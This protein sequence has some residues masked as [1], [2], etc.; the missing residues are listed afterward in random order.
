MPC[1]LAQA[2]GIVLALYLELGECAFFV[3][4]SLL[5]AYPVLTCYVFPEER[6]VRDLLLVYWG[7]FG[8]LTAF[9]RFL[10]AVPLYYI[11][12]M[13]LLT[14]FF[15]EPCS[16]A[17]KINKLIEAKLEENNLLTSSELRKICRRTGR[18][19]I[20]QKPVDLYDEKKSKEAPKGD[21]GPLGPT[22]KNDS[23]RARVSSSQYIKCL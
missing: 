23:P 2:M 10:E 16:F 20:P 12:K 17:E 18:S 1:Q 8:L 21:D 11:C 13:C 3:A 6:P 19:P 14:L 15:L 5:I 22:Q 4:N 7:C 9:D